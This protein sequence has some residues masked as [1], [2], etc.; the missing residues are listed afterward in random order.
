MLRIERPM[1]V[2]VLSLDENGQIVMCP[3]YEEK[4]KTVAL[5]GAKAVFHATSS[6]QRNGKG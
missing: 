6:P 2:T 1:W 5:R 4:K 3:G